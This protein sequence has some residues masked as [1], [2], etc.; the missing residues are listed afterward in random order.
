MPLAAPFAALAQYSQFVV[1]S[2]NNK[3]PVNNS[4]GSSI[5]PHLPE[6]W[7]TYED[8]ETLRIELGPDYY[9]AFVLTDSDPFWCL[10]IDGCL[11]PDNTWSETAQKLCAQFNGAAIEISCSGSGL[12]IMG[13]GAIPP[14]R[15][16]DILKVHVELYHTKRPIM[17]TGSGAVGDISSDHTQA[18]ESLIAEYFPPRDDI[19]IDWSDGPC[20]GWTGPTN[21]DQL[22]EKAL[23]SKSASSVFNDKITFSAL[24]LAD[25]AALA[26]AYPDADRIYDCSG[27]DLALA[28]RLAF[29]T[30]KDCTRMETLMRR[31]GLVRDKWD[32]RD[33]YLS[34]T[35]LFACS[36]TVKVYDVAPSVPA[37]AKTPSAYVL[38]GDGQAALFKGCVYV[39]QN[40]KIF[41]P[42]GDL[43]DPEQF[44]MIFGRNRFTLDTLNQKVTKNA[45][46]AFRDSQLY[47]APQVH[48][49][50]FRPLEAPGAILQEDGIPVVNTWWPY[51]TPRASGDISLFLTHLHKLFPIEH[52]RSII[53][54]YMAACLQHQGVKFQWCPIVQ[55]C[56]GNGKSLLTRVVSEA[57]GHRYSVWPKAS[58]INSEYNDWLYGV[59]FIGIEEVFIPDMQRQMMEDLK[60]MITKEWDQ[61]HGKYK[62]KV[63]RYLFG[64]FLMTTN[65]KD[66]IRLNA[67]DRRFAPFY[68]PQQNP[69][70][71]RREGMDADYF[72]ALYGWLNN[73]GYAMVTDYLWRYDIPTEFNPALGERAPITSSFEEALELGTG[74]LEQEILEQ[75][76]QN[77][78]GF[79]GG[80]ISS[81]ALQQL[82][83]VMNLRKRISHN[84]QRSILN[85]LGYDW[86]PGLPNGRVSNV[87]M[88]DHG[89]PKLYIHKTSPLRDLIVHAE[90]VQAYTASQNTLFIGGAS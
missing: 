2:G 78:Q 82:L 30:G 16:R 46:E 79:A 70:D 8:A 1:S 54:A 57:I 3:I 60:D 84:R 9:L 28:M 69:D 80:W 83:E 27:A 32:I 15:S 68:T 88:P 73:G 75:V 50:T 37:L 33:S 48:G 61:I 58:Q 22:L 11:L 42:G 77:T 31:S 86:H 89:K 44:Q 34:D 64:N 67:G 65:H 6:N 21:D 53:L 49:A 29:W 59:T 55:G 26:K 52:D 39:R 90:I 66:A 13:S 23:N 76:H 35:I 87:I 24:W 85:S 25:E 63:M 74:L 71:L 12:H 17:L 51:E 38:D 45:W 18:L 47:H 5:N 41:L 4:T 7:L 43:V 36:K 72:R 62:A 19:V 81:M 10:D 20:L 40:H 56:Q 14:H